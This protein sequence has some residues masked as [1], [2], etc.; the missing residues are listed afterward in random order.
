MPDDPQPLADE[1][2]VEDL[3]RIVFGNRGRLFSAAGKSAPIA[4][5]AGN[6]L[7]MH[8]PDKPFVDEGPAEEIVIHASD[9]GV[10]LDELGNEKKITGAKFRGNELYWLAEKKPGTTRCLVGFFDEEG[11][12]HHIYMGE[13]PITTDIAFKL[14][15]RTH[16]GELSIFEDLSTEPRKD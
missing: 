10:M 16:D 8:P 14:R 12:V 5:F 3:S 2:G 13:Q 9:R 1:L 15:N 7:V 4:E 6:F 11:K